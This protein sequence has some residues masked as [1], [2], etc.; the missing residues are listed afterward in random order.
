MGGEHGRRGPLGWLLA[1]LLAIGVLSSGATSEPGGVYEGVPAALPG[2]ERFP[3][4]LRARLAGAL[5]A[6]GPEYVPRTKHRRA[7]GAPRYTNRLIL[8]ASPYLQQHAH[9]P[10]D[11][12]PWGDE[13]F[14][15]ARRLRRPVLVSIGYA[16]CHWCHV[17]EEES[18]DDPEVAALLNAHF[19][20]IK[21]DR[22]VRPDVDAVYMT[23]L[24]AMAGQGGWPLNVW[25]TPER[26]P[27]HA[28][29]YFPPRDQPGRPGF[30]SVLRSV[31]EAW[32]REPERL[33][34]TAERLTS[35]LRTHLQGEAT[36]LTR[37]ADADPLREARAAL[38]GAFDPV[39]GG[40]GDRP[41]FPARLPVRF[42]LRWHRRTGDA[43]SLRMAVLTLERMAAGGI[44]DQVGGG[45]HRYATD[46]RWHVPHFEKMLYDNALRAIEYLEAWQVTGRGDFAG[47][48]RRTLDYLAHEMTAP[49][50][51]FYSATDA[52]SP[53]PE[54]RFEEGLFF[55]W[56]ADEVRAV[57]DARTAAAALAYWDVDEPGELE[58]RNVLWTP[59]ALE[60]V[61][62]RLEREPAALRRELDVARERL[63]QARSRRP[64]PLRDDKI[65]VAW[66][67]LAIQAFARAG[68]A[69]NEPAWIDAAARA[70]DFVLEQ[71]RVEGRLQRAFAAGRPL[72]PAFLEDYAFLVAGLLDLHEARPDPRWLREAL[73]LQTVLDGHYADAAQGGYYRTADDHER[74]LAREKPVHD[75]ALPSGN[76][77]AARNLLRLHELTGEDRFLAG[78]G[79]LLSAFHATL[80]RE[81]LAAAELLLALET[82]L[83][84]IKQIVLVRSAGAEDPPALLAPLRRSYAPNG[85]VVRVAEGKDLAAHAVLIPLVAGKVARDG[86]AT[87]YVC[88]NRV[89][90]SPTTDPEVFA[91]QL[92]HVRPLE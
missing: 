10:V 85:V 37:V 15:A 51:G 34:R 78:A 28:G 12:R 32:Q 19:V 67:G 36:Q 2:A 55:T 1:G 7:D 74:L 57:L 11:W 42:L 86:R 17:M 21:V 77:V 59:L 73:A 29:T 72:G 35:A 91:R 31:H 83:D 92:R 46:R 68:F 26:K 33:G 71:L 62:T 61:A 6:R 3:A 69:L 58:G 13:A 4:A 81:P 44:H 80:D 47:V 9:N 63:R 22:E 87:A 24:Q 16:T 75:G 50:G 8:E 66:N 56:T 48:V 90:R 39:W 88:E 60:R 45:F 27:F 65:L 18:F 64:P 25:V 5:A 54:G 70:A 76:A 40:V 23:A 82:R 14:E 38:Q 89:C 84:T 49:E 53:G 41:K 30:P 20:A 79:A 43:E 52:D